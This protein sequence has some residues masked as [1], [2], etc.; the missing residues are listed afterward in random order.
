VYQSII[1]TFGDG[2]VELYGDEAQFIL[3]NY[4][5]GSPPAPAIPPS[6][7]EGGMIWDASTKELKIHDGTAFNPTTK[8]WI[9]VN[10][11]VNFT[12]GLPNSGQAG[13][14]NIAIGNNTQATGGGAGYSN[15]AAGY[16]AIASS[17]NAVAL[18]TN[19]STTHSYAVSIG[20]FTQSGANSQ[21]NIGYG[22]VGDGTIKRTTIGYGAS[23]VVG[24]GALQSLVTIYDN[25]KVEPIG[26]KAMFVAPKYT[27]ATLPI[28]VEGGM[29]YVS[30]ATATTGTGSQCFGRSTGSPP[31]LEWIDVT[32]SIAVV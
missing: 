16:N 10:G 22:V 8:N 27:I 5:V 3:P 28:V 6:T 25:G 15:M 18:G 26:D 14:N 1:S 7:I 2:K 24:V 13:N 19:T 12:T 31:T 21:V 11:G 17:Y 9:S 20:A 30:D 29:I 23:S 32:T 4:L